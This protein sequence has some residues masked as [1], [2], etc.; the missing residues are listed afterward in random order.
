MVQHPCVQMIQLGRGQLAALLVIRS[1]VLYEPP[2]TEVQGL[3][4]VI[5]HILHL[6]SRHLGDSFC[7][8][9]HLLRSN[10]KHLMTKNFLSEMLSRMPLADSE[11]DQFPPS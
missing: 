1:E 8:Q 6:F 10:L 9:A 11:E 3:N 5:S 4:K 2:N 7:S